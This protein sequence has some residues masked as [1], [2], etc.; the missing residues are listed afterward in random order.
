M[1]IVTVF[2]SLEN[3]SIDKLQLMHYQNLELS[4]DITNHDLTECA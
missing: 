4:R 1:L 2:L 3:I